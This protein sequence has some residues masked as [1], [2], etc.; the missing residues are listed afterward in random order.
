MNILITGSEGFVGQ[1]MVW[2]LREIRDGKNRTRPDL[3]ID[4]IFEYDTK[5]RYEELES[6]CEKADFVFHFAGVNRP[7]NIE[8]FKKGNADFT[9]ELLELLIKKKN[10]CPV[11][12][13]SSIQASLVGRFANSEYGKSKLRAEEIFFEYGKRTGA[14]VLVYRF[15]N[16][17]GKWS[18]PNYNSVVATFCNAI[19]NDLEYKMNDPNTELELLYIDDFFEGMLDALE[20]KEKHC[21]YDGLKVCEDIRGRYCYIPYTHRVT[22]G[23]IVEKLKEYKTITETKII[24]DIPEGSFEKKLLSTY[25]TY[26]PQ[27]KLVYNLDMK[28]DNRGSFTEL[29]KTKTSGQISINITKP[30]ITKGEHWHNT[31]WEIFMVVSGHGLIQERRLGIDPATRKEYPIIEFEVNGNEMKAVQMIPGYTHNIIN[32]SDSEDLITVMWANEQFDAG[33]PDTFYE[34]VT[35]N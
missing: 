30:G 18:R 23:Y 4:D 31:K 22:L 35:P 16:L 21:E 27:D 26:L 28:I 17:F 6:A 24:P 3:K 2:N 8:E 15:T 34:A 12:L 32:L 10:T 29:I 1:N 20:E 19:A 33:H 5:S 25:L 11:L 7:K 9:V 14:K 13:S